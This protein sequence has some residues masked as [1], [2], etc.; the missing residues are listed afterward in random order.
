MIHTEQ[1]SGDALQF[2]RYLPWAAERC[3]RLLVV[4]PER[5]HRLYAT[6]PGIDELRP[7][8]SFA[9]DE[10]QAYLPLLS[11]PLVFQTT[12]ETV[13]NQVPYI[14]APSERIPLPP[15]AIPN[16]RLKVGLNWAGKSSYLA[17]EKRS[18]TPREF[19]PLLQVPDIAYYSLQFGEGAD[20]LPMLGELQSRV[21]DLNG[22]HDDFADTAGLMEQLDVIVSVDTAPVHLA[23]ALAR[24]VCVAVAY[25]ADWRWLLF[26]EDSC[27]Y[28]TARVFR[29]SQPGNWESVFTNIATALQQFNKE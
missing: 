8:G 4:C 13:P 27:W 20:Q 25:D 16:P 17:D 29:Q 2:A 6:I 23:G 1:G 12:V 9:A 5:L 21:V 18:C 7:A 11:L 22:L 28:P 15:P 10:F 3:K 14:Q 26:R 19:M 24:P